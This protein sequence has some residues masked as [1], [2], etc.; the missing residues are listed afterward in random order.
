L[1]GVR[2]H[3]AHEWVWFRQSSQSPCQ[4]RPAVQGPVQRPATRQKLPGGKNDNPKQRQ[5]G[6][7]E[8]VGL[9]GPGRVSPSRT[10]P[11]VR[12]A[13][14]FSVPAEPGGASG[15]S[16]AAAASGV[17]LDGLLMLQAAE[18]AT[19]RNRKARRH[20]E[21]MLTELAGLLRA[22]LTGDTDRD[23]L[24][25]LSR[26]LDSAPRADDPT[27]DAVLQPVILRARVE[28]IRRQA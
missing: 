13:R 15:A 27:L 25:Q 17:M 8:S 26:L 23:A 9:D 3:P 24:M 6:M 14:G 20:G 10:R 4:R 16:A 21:A 12:G 22:L 19:E 1:E 18:D 11:G 7:I 2:G 5:D 28:L